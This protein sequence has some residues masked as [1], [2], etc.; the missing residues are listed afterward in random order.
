MKEIKDYTYSD[1]IQADEGKLEV[2]NANLSNI[3]KMKEIKDFSF[4]NVEPEYEVKL[5][6]IINKLKR[7]A[8]KYEL[9]HM[10]LP[11]E[12]IK[13]IADNTTDYRTIESACARLIAYANI[14][15][16]KNITL[17]MAK[18][19]IF[20]NY[21]NKQIEKDESILEILE[22]KSPYEFLK[23]KLGRKPSES[24]TK[25]LEY[26]LIDK[27]L[28]PSGV[29]L[30]V[31][32]ILKT[33]DN[34]LDIELTKKFASC[35]KNSSLIN[36]NETLKN[37]IGNAEELISMFEKEFQRNL[38]PTEIETVK[39]LLETY[40]YGEISYALKAAAIN[41]VFNLRYIIKV[42]EAYYDKDKQKVD[43]EKYDYNWL[44][45]K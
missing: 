13:F 22:T 9:N 2:I 43:N 16:I 23:E 7:D 44:D 29:N 35:F 33:H 10:V 8:D 41:G 32:Y 17:D 20:N 39:E 27:Q 4:L 18:D 3:D 19:K 40:T 42:L 14:D 31:D 1:I 24:E 30:L 12:V 25:L 37:N 28:I 36:T 11:I 15:R 21:F 26:L 5:G 34:Q 45:E 38:T 6:F